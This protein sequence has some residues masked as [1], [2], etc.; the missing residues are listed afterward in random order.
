MDNVNKGAVRVSSSLTVTLSEQDV[1]RYVNAIR[2]HASV[3][4]ASVLA[5]N[6][7]SVKDGLPVAPLPQIPY[8]GVVKFARLCGEYNSLGIYPFWAIGGD[9][10]LRI[11]RD[12]TPW[13]VLDY[14]QGFV[15]GAVNDRGEEVFVDIYSR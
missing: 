5:G 4:A 9:K 13:Q 12:I 15:V 1:H 7:T 10:R 2:N 8:D 3:I 6:I 11:G 14:P